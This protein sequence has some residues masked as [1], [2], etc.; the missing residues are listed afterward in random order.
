MPLPELLAALE[1]EGASGEA[2]ELTRAADEAERLRRDAAGE[3]TARTQARLAKH[4]RAL[5]GQAEQRL[6]EARRQAES[7][8]LEARHKLL[9]AVFE[10]A[11]TL[12]EEV[13]LWKSYG[14]AL[15]RDVHLLLGLLT[16]EELVLRCAEADRAAVAAA[17]GPGAQVVASADVTVGVRVGSADGRVEMDRSLAARLAGA[18]ATLAIRVMQRLEGGQ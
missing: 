12:Q 7:R 11:L 8:V 17:A 18:R 15:K 9:D 3:E 16:G 2:E 1:R 4:A 14:A 13:R 6:L 5:H 10:R